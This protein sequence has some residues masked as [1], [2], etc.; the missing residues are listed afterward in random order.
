MILFYWLLQYGS[1]FCRRRKMSHQADDVDDTKRV[2][3]NAATMLDSGQPSPDQSDGPL[4]M[5]RDSA[6][7]EVICEIEAKT[8]AMYDNFETIDWHRDL[9]RDRCRTRQL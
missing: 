1:L 4:L 6:D 2:L 3:F 9:A 5:S 7:D 8:S